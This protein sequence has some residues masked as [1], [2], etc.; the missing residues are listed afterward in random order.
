[1]DFRQLRYFIEIA[2]QG[3]FTKAAGKLRITQPSLGC[4]IKRLEGE[5]SNPHLAGEQI[6]K[7]LGIDV[8]HIPYKGSADAMAAFASNDFR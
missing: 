8:V 7:M 2:E 6:K 1:M 4:Q 5:G 3:S